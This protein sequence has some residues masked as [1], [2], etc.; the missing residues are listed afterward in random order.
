MPIGATLVELGPIPTEML[1]HVDNY[2]P[3]GDSFDRFYKLR[4]IVDVP[5]EKVAESVVDAVRRNKRHVR[6]PPRAVAFPLLTEAPR[7]LTELLLTRVK[8]QED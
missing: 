5:R 1:D 3:T 6:F 2:R 8:H 7:R 4:L